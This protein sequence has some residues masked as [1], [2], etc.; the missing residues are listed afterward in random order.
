[1]IRN[2]PVCRKCLDSYGPPAGKMSIFEIMGRSFVLTFGLLLVFIGSRFIYQMIAV[3]QF[4]SA[5][6]MVLSIISVLIGLLVLGITA[7]P[8][9]R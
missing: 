4:F 7:R 3:P 9:F 8:F 6:G 1:M 5:L 2:K